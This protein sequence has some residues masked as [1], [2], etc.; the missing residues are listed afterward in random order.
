MPL[1]N[2][3]VA[4]EALGQ[5]EAR[6]PLA[7]AFCSACRLAQITEPVSPEMLFRDYAYFSSVSDAMVEHARGLVDQVI[8]RAGLDQASLV[9]ELASND[10]YLLQHYVARG[11]PVLGIE[12]ARNI[13][14][15]AEARGVPTIAEFFG[16]DLARQL[17]RSGRLADVLHAH[18]VLAHVPDVHGFIEGMAEI[19]KPTGLAVI[20]TPYVKDL[21]DRLEFDTIY[22][23]HVYYHSL[24]SLA[25]LLGQHG[26]AIVDV[27]R[28]AIHGGSLRVFAAHEAAGTADAAVARL[29]E[30]EEASGV[31]Q[32]DYFVG[33]GRRVQALGEQ[34]RDVLADF[35]SRGDSM[36]GYGAAAKGAVLLNAFGI[37]ADTLDFVADRSPHKQGYHMPGVH[38]PIVP[39][40]RLVEAMPAA[41]LLL[42]WNFADEILA[43]Q[44]QYRERGGQFIVPGPTVRVL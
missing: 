18:N 30:E 41:T 6:F 37:G 1:A 14:D 13:A 5:P 21:V 40:E 4:A 12:P 42:A 15:V 11:V 33:F 25:R 9:V 28:I 36:A 29:L 20:E 22:H 2:A 23:E 44:Q 3:L 10:G 26:L 16:A 7:L 38:I 19:L 32:S 35:R 17:A 39:A 24:T 31:T 34:L 8:R 27:E 43:Q